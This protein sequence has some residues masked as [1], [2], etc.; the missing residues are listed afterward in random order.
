M[1]LAYMLDSDICIYAMRDRPAAVQ[2]RFEMHGGELCI[3]MITLAELLYGAEN[4]RVGRKTCEPWKNLAVD[5][6]C[7]RF[8]TVLPYITDSFARSSNG[9]VFRQGRM[10]C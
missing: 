2:R 8:R 6:R 9:P 4:R 3:S 1:T 10:T 5:W 7:C